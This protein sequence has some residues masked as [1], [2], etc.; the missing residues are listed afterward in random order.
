MTMLCSSLL[1]RPFSMGYLDFIFSE[2][3]IEVYIGDSAVEL[4]RRCDTK[5]FC[6]PL[7]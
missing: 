1:V 3:P 6:V 5:Y 7:D 4:R 2:W